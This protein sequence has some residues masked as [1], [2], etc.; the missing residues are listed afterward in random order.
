MSDSYLVL[1][2]LL[3]LG[4]LALAGFVGCDRVFGLSPV[5]PVTLDN[6]LVVGENV[7][8]PRNDFTGW[9]GMAIVPSPSDRSISAIG[10][11]CLPGNNQA[12]VLKIV[13][14][15]TGTD[16]PGTII[17]ISMAN[18]PPNQFV[19]VELPGPQPTLAA[20]RTYFVLSH[21]MGSGDQF[22]DFTTT[23]DVASGAPFVIVSAVFGDPTASPPVPFAQAGNANQSYGPVNVYY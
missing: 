1:T 8:S 18:Q 3:V 20:G 19:Y 6:P 17:T 4:V 14:A 11:Y 21:E 13:D 5:P 12:H 23:L 22:Y 10:R 9:V 7:M 16:V 15:S 2:P